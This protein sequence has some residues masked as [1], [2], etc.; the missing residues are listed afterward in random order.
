[1]LDTWRG[2]RRLMKRLKA[3]AKTTL[4]LLQAAKLEAEAAARA[5]REEFQELPG[6]PPSCPRCG[7]SLVY[8]SVQLSRKKWRWMWA[9]RGTC[10]YTVYD[11]QIQRQRSA[12]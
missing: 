4:P 12:S 2:R 8:R 3:D 1:M 9:C 10:S 7:R 6:F 5:L 11:A